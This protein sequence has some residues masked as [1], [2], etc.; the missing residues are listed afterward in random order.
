MNLQRRSLFAIISGSIISLFSPGALAA[1]GPLVKPKRLGQVII[2]RNKKYTAIKK[3][4]LLVWD[5]GV[6]IKAA[7]SA[8][9]TASASATPKPSATVTT[10]ALTLVAKLSDISDGETKVI[11]IKPS[12]GAS[13]SVAVSKV[14][15]TV[16]VFSATCTHQGC[17]VET[18]GNELGCPC[19]GSAFNPHTGAVIQGPA[20][21]A[22]K[23]YAVSEEAG[24]IYIKI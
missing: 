17:I 23:K 21:S 13:F 22:L 15:G 14:G 12:S 24:S 16:T 11:L 9:P 3:G 7:A 19:H 18:V 1:D 10:S 6:A 4:K 5:K 20:Q 8:S 2:F